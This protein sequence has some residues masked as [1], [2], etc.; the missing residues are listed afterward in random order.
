MGKSVL[1][2]LL[3]PARK[4]DG[5]REM[6]RGGWSIQHSTNGRYLLRTLFIFLLPSFYTAFYL[7]SIR[8]RLENSRKVWPLTCSS[9]HRRHRFKQSTDV[10]VRWGFLLLHEPG[11][12]LLRKGIANDLI[13][14]ENL[15]ILNAITD[16]KQELV[17]FLL[18]YWFTVSFMDV[19]HLF[20]STFYNFEMEALASK[21][22]SNSPLPSVRD[23]RCTSWE[24][25][26]L[27]PNSAG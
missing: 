17:D 6:G 9:I 23:I 20:F 10:A 14:K 13:T 22:Q 19:N 11:D 27:P 15:D 4:R 21:T 25:G 16:V 24:S 7:P 8:P 1:L 3:L 18:K 12:R 26:L 2:A 5:M